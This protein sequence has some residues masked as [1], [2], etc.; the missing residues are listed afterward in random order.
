MTANRMCQCTRC[1]NKHLESER[2]SVPH[3]TIRGGREMVCPRCGGK[4]FYD[5]TPAKAWCTMSGV[6]EVGT[7]DEQPDPAAGQPI[8]FATGPYGD[9]M[10]RLR[11]EADV[12]GFT[13]TVPGMPEAGDE[14]D[15]RVTLRLWVNRLA[16]DNGTR[17]A[18]GVVFDLEVEA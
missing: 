16:G 1:R 18:R 6:I 3:K 14:D 5:I 8:F 15:A 13:W 2:N 7:A 9:L 4:S 12:L 10:G 17:Y 11:R